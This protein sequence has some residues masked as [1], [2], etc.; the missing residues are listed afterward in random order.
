MEYSGHRVD[1]VYIL[2]IVSRHCHGC[3]ADVLSET[4]TV[5]TSVSDGSRPSQSGLRARPFLV[6][7]AVKVNKKPWPSQALAAA[8]AGRTYS[9]VP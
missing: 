4:K 1:N 6:A 7:R 8:A 9:L 5:W 3:E 2:I